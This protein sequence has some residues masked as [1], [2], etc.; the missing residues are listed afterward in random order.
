MRAARE[1]RNAG[2]PRMAF[3]LYDIFWSHY[4]E[5]AR[6]CLDF[7]RLSY[8]IVR[9]NP[10]TRRQVINLGLR[11]DVPVLTDGPRV[12]AGSGAIAAHLDEVCPDPPLVPREPHVREA[13]LALQAKCDEWLGPDTRRVAYE[14]A[15][16]NPVILV[17]T[18][19]W[20]R[21]PKRWLNRLLLRIVEP[22]VRRKFK[23][24]PRELQESRE[25]LRQFLP[26]L[27][28]AIARTGFLVGGRMT[29]ADLAA[30]SLLDPLEIV[31]EFVRD[32]A[33]APLF[34]WKRALARAHRRRQRTPWLSGPPP[35]GYPLLLPEDD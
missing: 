13:A 28:S 27:Q 20:A 14:V 2:S 9:V 5:K 6:F 12:I 35:P 4:C 15:L 31:P 16:E 23:I 18:I 30:V 32:R 33:Y 22:R 26:E 17:G 25:R 8:T 1:T 7:K 19:L 21:P 29:I 10:F 11:G 34:A 24:F 3:V